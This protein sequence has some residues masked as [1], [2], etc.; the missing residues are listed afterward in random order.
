MRRLPARTLDGHVVDRAWP[1]L[2]EATVSQAAAAGTEVQATADIYKQAYLE[3][4]DAGHADG[5]QAARVTLAEAEETAR[6][7]A[8]SARETMH[9]WRE[10]IA[11]LAGRFAQAETQLH[12]DMEALAVEIAFAAT[13]RVVGELHT[14][15][16][17]VAALCREAVTEL[18]LTPTQLRVSPSDHCHLVEKNLEM[19]CV[20]DP[21]LG[22]GGCL[23]ETA[24]GEI[25]TGI[26]TRLQA[27]LHAL[28]D[29]MRRDE[30]AP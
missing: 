26:E 10:Q 30:V 3:G 13:C 7:M 21:A 16:E 4:F 25:E 27:V 1:T 6:A 8:E 2:D 28:L 17:L 12:Q 11:A 29:S 24:L 20:A 9:D 22:A 5:D 19:P 18:Q 14:R 15:R 23:I